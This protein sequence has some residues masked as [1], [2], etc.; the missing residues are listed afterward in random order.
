MAKKISLEVILL[1]SLSCLAIVLV[2]SAVWVIEVF[3]PIAQR[4]A[5]LLTALRLFLNFGTPAFVFMSEFLLAKSYPD[6]LPSGFFLKRFK[7]LVIPFICM[8]M[9]YAYVDMRIE[10]MSLTFG[11]FVIE[12]L[13]NIVLGDYVGYFILVIMQFYLLHHL[14]HRRLSASRPLNMLTLAFAIN[15]VY[16]GFFNFVPPFGFPG[17]EKVWNEYS[18]L[19]ALGWVFYFALGYYCGKHYDTMLALLRKHKWKVLLAPVPLFLILAA[20]KMMD[21]PETTS[22]KTVFYL[23]FSPSMIFFVFLIAGWFKKIPSIFY[24]ISDYSFSIYLLHTLAFM[25]VT[26]PLFL[27]NY[28]DMNVY[29][30]TAIIFVTSVLLSM[31]AGYLIN[32]LPPGKYIVGPIRTNYKQAKRAAAPPSPLPIP[33]DVSAVS[34]ESSPARALSSGQ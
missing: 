3:D 33:G 23:A 22:S 34:P 12:S 9:I 30:K 17:A 31:L 5:Q 4:D 2:H 28:T 1:R 24:L 7:F 19:P 18:W 29:L 14:F 6:R 27:T 8:G 21:I 25:L 26:R 15:F 32:K 10:G 20:L 16:L 13:K 11:T